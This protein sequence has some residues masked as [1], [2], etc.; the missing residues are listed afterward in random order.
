MGI[1]TGFTLHEL[2]VRTHKPFF[3]Y[4]IVVSIACITIFEGSMFVPKR[5]QSSL[6]SEPITFKSIKGKE[7]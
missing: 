7:L 5:V 1:R 3:L 2:T 6:K 4:R